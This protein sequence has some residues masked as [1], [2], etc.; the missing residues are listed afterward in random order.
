MTKWDTLHHVVSHFFVSIFPKELKM[1]SNYFLKAI[2]V[3]PILL[4]VMCHSVLLAQ[5]NMQGEITGRNVNIRS[6]AGTNY[7]IVGTIQQGKIVD[8]IKVEGSWVQID[9]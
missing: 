3:L 9:L 2:Q 7:P 5:S 6:G 1:L 8:V 4:W